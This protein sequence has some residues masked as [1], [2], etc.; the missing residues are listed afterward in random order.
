MCGPCRKKPEYANLG[1]VNCVSKRICI[2]CGKFASFGIEK[3][4][5][6][7]CGGCKD[8]KVDS[9]IYTDVVSS[10][11]VDCPHDN[12]TRPSYGFESMG[13][14]THC[15][16]HAVIYNTNN[17]KVEQMV[18]LA[19]ERC[20]DCF[21]RAESIHQKN[22]QD[23]DEYEYVKVPRASYAII[24]ESKPRYCGTCQDIYIDVY[25]T[26]KRCIKC[27]ENIGCSNVKS[28][29]LTIEQHNQLSRARFGLNKTEKYCKEHKEVGM[30]DSSKLCLHCTL[31]PS[32]GKKGFTPIVCLKCLHNRDEY[33]DELHLYFNHTKKNCITPLCD[34]SAKFYAPYCLRC[35]VFTYSVLTYNQKELDRV[36]KIKFKESEVFK[37][38]NDK[39][40]DK[41]TIVNDKRI[42]NTC[43]YRRPDIYIDLGFRAIIV[44]I[45]EGEHVYYNK[46]CEN[47]RVMELWK[48]SGHNNLV[49]IR[50]NPDEYTDENGQKHKSCWVKAKLGGTYNPREGHIKK[51][52]ERLTKLAETV[53]YYSNENNIVDKTVELVY[54][55]YTV[56]KGE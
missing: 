47:R 48:D 6:L 19:H 21:K 5:P 43:S 27:L 52:K 7:Y 40:K 24:G 35:H 13:K 12:E 56:V 4:V 23:G 36:P 15:K 53:E 30:C 28:C 49:I 38:L 37:F 16:E 39:F 18:D 17:P 45:D 42:D 44:E 41:F 20:E 46:T 11:C 10:Y 55:Y 22:E 32:F 31:R 26:H 51:W 8:K 1:F 25:D 54:L 29:N 2:D 3:K 50:F 14:K 34:V 9:H 33:K